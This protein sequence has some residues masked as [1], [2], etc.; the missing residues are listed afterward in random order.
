MSVLKLIAS[1]FFI[2]IIMWIFIRV[3][4]LVGKLLHISDIIIMISK[5]LKNV[6]VKIMVCVIS[7]FTVVSVLRGTLGDIYAVLCFL[8]LLLTFV[9]FSKIDRKGVDDVG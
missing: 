1:I 3:M 2:V 6:F 7:I 9:D 8:V 4:A 5:L